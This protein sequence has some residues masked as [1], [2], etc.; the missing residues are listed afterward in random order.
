MSPEGDSR[1]TDGSG[2]SHNDSGCVAGTRFV[3][4]FLLMKEFRGIPKVFQALSSVPE[5]G[6]KGADDSVKEPCKMSRPQ[7]VLLITTWELGSRRSSGRSH[8][9]HTKPTITCR[10]SSE[11]TAKAIGTAAPTPFSSGEG[12]RVET[13]RIGGGAT[14]PRALFP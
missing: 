10:E 3:P 4:Q 12:T 2:I 1:E 14:C 13:Q 7:G 6:E 5:A 8:Q 11:T 9:R